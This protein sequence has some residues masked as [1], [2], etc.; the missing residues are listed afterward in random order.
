MASL[1]SLTR[2]RPSRRQLAA[3]KGR[4]EG[5]QQHFAGTLCFAAKRRNDGTMII[6]A[7][8]CEPNG[9]LAAYKRRWQIECLFGDIKTR[10]L[11]M[12]DTKLTQ[13]AKLSLLMA[14]VALALAWAHACASATKGHQHRPRKPWLPSKVVVQNRLRCPAALDRQPS[15]QGLGPVAQYLEPPETKSLTCQSRVV[16]GAHGDAFELFEFAEEILDQMTPFVYLGIERDRL[17]SARM[18][19]DDDLGA[20]LVQIGDDG[21]AV[22]GFVGDQS[23]EGEAWMSGSTPTVSKRWPGSRTKRTRLP[24][25]SVSA[26]ILVVMPPLERAMAWL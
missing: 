14:V 9:A 2:R 5:M 7:T 12:E 18:L 4:F 26:M 11:N 21:V 16:C 1:A 8:N 24:S 19:G 20:T 23:A 15:R 6:I 25:A 22:E 3:Y 10:G 13:P 17:C